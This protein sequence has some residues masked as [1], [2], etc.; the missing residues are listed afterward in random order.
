[1]SLEAF[2]VIIMERPDGCFLDRSVHPLGLTVG[3][4]MVRP[5]QPVLDAMLETNAI[6]D[7]WSEEPSGWSL[8]VL[9]QI[10]EGHAIIGQDLVYLI[11][12][13]RDDVSE[14]GGTF[15]FPRVL[16]EL[17]VGELRYP[18]DGEGFPSAW[19]SSALSMWT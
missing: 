9:R 11:R 6:E 19:V 3:P 14:E 2:Q 4:G 17:D 12:K 18:V 15:H 10:G 8:T 13:G 7:M 5:G 16:V 1:M